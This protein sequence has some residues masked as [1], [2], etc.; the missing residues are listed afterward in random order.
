MSGILH[1]WAQ[2]THDTKMKQIRMPRGTHSGSVWTRSPGWLFRRPIP[3][4][5]CARPQGEFWGTLLL[6]GNAGAP[7]W[8]RYAC[9][10]HPAGTAWTDLTGKMPWGRAW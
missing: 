5:P 8:A 1:L 3:P 9:C 6:P 2:S 4:A 10:Q 7:G